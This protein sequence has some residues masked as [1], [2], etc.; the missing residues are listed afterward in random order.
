[1]HGAS[2]F[3]VTELTRHNGEFL[4]PGNRLEIKRFWRTVASLDNYCSV[5]HLAYLRFEVRHGIRTFAQVVVVVF[6]FVC[7]RGTV[8]GTCFMAVRG[9]IR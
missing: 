7:S 5:V 3:G 1:M 8:K 9:L 6:T 4:Y 2:S